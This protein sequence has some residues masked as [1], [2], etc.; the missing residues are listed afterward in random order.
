MRH[1]IR[2]GVRIV[3]GLFAHPVLAQSIMTAADSANVAKTAIRAIW[4]AAQTYYQDKGKWPENLAALTEPG[5][6]GKRTFPPYVMTPAQTIKE[7]KFSLRYGGPPVMISATSRTRTFKGEGGS[8]YPRYVDYDVA[9]GTWSGYGI[10]IYSKD[11][12]T[13]PQKVELADDAK[14]AMRLVWEGAKVFYND[15]GSWPE[16]TEELD[17]DH[18]IGLWSSAET[19]KKG[20]EP[21]IVSPSVFKQWQFA[22]IGSP[23]QSVIA[24]STKE[25]PG[26]AGKGIEY[27]VEKKTWR[28]YGQK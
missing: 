6:Y 15:K 9:K 12:L 8:R 14:N 20:E 13:A 1:H 18:Y 21:H 25:M 22:I 5:H 2:F 4:E 23:P 7:W 17:A 10:P 11:T 16:T 24:V 3:L 26:G 28:G 27:D 19:F